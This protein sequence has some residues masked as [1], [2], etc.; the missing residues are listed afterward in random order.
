MMLN[1]QRSYAAIV[2]NGEGKHGRPPVM[3][4]AISLSHFLSLPIS[5]P[6]HTKPLRRA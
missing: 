5:G 2:A 4:P 6:S 1:S 3:M